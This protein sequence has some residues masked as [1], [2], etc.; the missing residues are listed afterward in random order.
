MNVQILEIATSEFVEA[1][2]SAITT[3]DLIELSKSK[4]GDGRFPNFDWA[5]VGKICIDE[6]YKLEIN[7]AILGLIQFFHE[8]KIKKTIEIYK[9][10]VSKENV[11]KGKIYDRIAGCLI[12]YACLAA[13]EFSG[14]LYLFYKRIVKQIYVEKYGMQEHNN[15]YVLSD[16]TNCAS[17]IK[18]YLGIDFA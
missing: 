6:V 12:A 13:Q 14:D 15:F 10:E 9:L 3:E 18:K 4:K 1:R 16:Q 5:D 2:I 17:L 7:G 8:R 11:G